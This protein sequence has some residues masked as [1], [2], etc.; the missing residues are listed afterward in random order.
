MLAKRE[1]Y[2]AKHMGAYERIYPSPNQELQELYEKLLRG[3]MELF[4]SSFQVNIHA[5]GLVHLC[6]HVQV[7][8]QA[9]ALTCACMQEQMEDAPISYI[10]LERYRLF[11]CARRLRQRGPL[12]LWERSVGGRCVAFD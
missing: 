12:S 7:L 4:Q 10:L 2:E 6:A 1:K 5:R 11:Y 8:V 3:A 9:C